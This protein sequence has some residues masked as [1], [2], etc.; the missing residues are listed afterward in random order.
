M[1]IQAYAAWE[2]PIQALSSWRVC[3]LLLCRCPEF[4]GFIC[5]LDDLIDELVN[6]ITKAIT[7]STLDELI[8]RL[9]GELGLKQVFDQLI[10]LVPAASDMQQKLQNAVQIAEEAEARLTGLYGNITQMQ[11]FFDFRQAPLFWGC[12]ACR[13]AQ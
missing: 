10:S 8:D 1:A 13:P 12:V 7:G 9:V 11:A 5:N 6:L 3:H 4:L 2:A